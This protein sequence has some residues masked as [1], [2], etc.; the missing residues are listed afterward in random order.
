M[1]RKI[2]RLIFVLSLAALLVSYIGVEQA[3]WLESYV[4]APLRNVYSAIFD[5]FSVPVFEILLLASPLLLIAPLV[6]RNGLQLLTFALVLV[7]S[8]Y[9]ITLAIPA[10]ATREDSVSIT[11]DELICATEL[12]A[13]RLSKIDTTVECE[14]LDAAV[15]E[16]VMMSA[17]LHYNMRPPT[18]KQSM[19][20]P[21]L[22]RMGILAFYAF[23]TGE[24]I[25][26]SQLPDFMRAFSVAHELMHYLGASREDHADFSAFLALASSGTPALEYSAYITA[27][28]HLGGAL[29]RSFPEEY[30]RIYTTLSADVK[31]SLNEK[32]E[33]L[34]ARQGSTVSSKLNDVAITLRDGRGSAS[35]S[36]AVALIAHH[37]LA[38]EVSK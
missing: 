37:V 9:C 35:Y 4:A 26:N 16:A 23:P 32:R 30:Y 2:T 7:F 29:Y 20:S 28:S 1:I 24:I 12:I 25:I 36:D 14:S 27:F 17:D 33:F 15:S 19:I 5:R 11:D 21:L 8:S 38:T 6:F 3:M 18:V 22:D 13:A 34:S 31:H 10:N